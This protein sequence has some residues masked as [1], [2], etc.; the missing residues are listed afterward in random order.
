MF[1]QAIDMVIIWSWGY[2]EGKMESRVSLSQ[3]TWSIPYR[4]NDFWTPC[5]GVYTTYDRYIKNK[6]KTKIL[7]KDSECKLN[8]LRFT[9]FSYKNCICPLNI[10]IVLMIKHPQYKLISYNSFCLFKCV[11]SEGTLLHLI[12][13]P[14]EQYMMCYLMPFK[15]HD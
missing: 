5:A 11:S 4:L 14:P 1:S 7:K 6:I 10:N 3:V 13:F 2:E 12:W 9:P 15:G 8:N